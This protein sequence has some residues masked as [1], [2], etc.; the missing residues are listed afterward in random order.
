MFSF[1]D[2]A[3]LSLWVLI[4]SIVNLLISV[5]FIEFVV[6]TVMVLLYV[7]IL[8]F[9]AAFL[10]GILLLLIILIL[11]VFLPTTLLLPRRKRLIVQDLPSFRLVQNPV[12]WVTGVLMRL[13]LRLRV[14]VQDVVVC[15]FHFLPRLRHW[16]QQSLLGDP[17]E[18]AIDRV[19]D[20]HAEELSVILD[21]IV[22]GHAVA[23]GE[24]GSGWLLLLVVLLLLVC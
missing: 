5:Q 2:I 1:R 13:F 10:F 16:S 15:V 23:L 4:P 11:T 3:T 19:V 20:V 21:F 8:V 24:R 14:V 18:T 6:L 9:G 7:L 22:V 17:E 12:G